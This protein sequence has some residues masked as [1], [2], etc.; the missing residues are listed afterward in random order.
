[1]SLLEALNVS[2]GALQAQSYGQRVAANN[3]ANVNTPGYSRQSATLTTN[4]AP[5]LGVQATGVQRNYDSIL[6][7][8]LRA[9]TG[10]LAD[11]GARQAYASRIEANL[12]PNGDGGLQTSVD[13]FFS[14]MRTLQATPTDN[15]ARQTVLANAQSLTQDVNAKYAALNQTRTDIDNDLVSTVNDANAL[16]AQISKIN[17]AIGQARGSLTQDAMANLS[18][19]RDNALQKL[20]QLVGGTAV[21]DASGQATVNVAGFSIVAGDTYRPLTTTI[22]ADG[23]HHVSIDAAGA[24]N[25]DGRLGQS[26]ASGLIGMRA[27][28]QA[29]MDELDQF[30][31]DFASAVNAQHASGYALDGS[32]GNSL[33]TTGAQNGAATFA[34]DASVAGQPNKLA[35]ASVAGT[36]GDSGN[37]KA[38]SNLETSLSAMG[39]TKTF[40]QS[41][42]SSI[43]AAGLSVQSAK[44]AVTTEQSQYDQIN[45]ALQSAAGV[46]L[47]EET[48]SL[49][50]YQRAYQAAAKVVSTVNDM[51]D[52][53]LNM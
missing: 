6:G 14:S 37:A 17:K 52:T 51:L 19:Q 12:D 53:L 46:S 2:G 42:A 23:T 47:D 13:K 28:T 49:A 5:L 1:M 27:E 16:A 11:A 48:L 18:D 35:M 36:V 34:V 3:I 9:Q 40:A 20:S 43:T 30:T 21:L 39:G 44:T 41:L 25:L 8:R 38:L 26:K 22:D 10:A 50:S 7:N 32:T 4:P 24:P 31:Q 15:N 29:R 45:E 33:F